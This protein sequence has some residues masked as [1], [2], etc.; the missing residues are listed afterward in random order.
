MFTLTKK[1]IKNDE[2][3]GGKRMNE[4]DVLLKK[5]EKESRIYLEKY[6]RDA[7]DWL[8]DAFQVVHMPKNRTF[9]AEGETADKVYILLKGMVLAV[10]HRVQEMAYGFIRFQPVEVF[11]VM[12]IMLELD[13]YK[14]TLM[15]TR[16]SVLLRT[17]RE[18][19]EKWIKNDINAFRMETKK[20]GT[21]LLEEV[22]KER[23]YVLV[24][25]VERVYLVLHELYQ[26]YAR[27]GVLRIYM[28]RKDFSE[29]T[30][31]S[32]RTITRTLKDL[33]QKGFLTRDGWNLVINKEQY[34]MLRALI[35]DKMCGI[36]G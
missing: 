17:S 21:Y 23:L 33:E 6:F 20:V 18:K 24:Q 31:V 26:T 36:G 13:E 15:T 34:L 32:E 1:Y 7:P 35:E 9:I 16:D 2:I 11:G 12:E 3:L 5:L 22:R 28:S 14:T 25:G 19:F 29:A 4:V 8:M 27:D 10:D 30:G